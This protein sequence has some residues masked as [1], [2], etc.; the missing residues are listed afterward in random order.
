[1]KSPY[2]MVK[3]LQIPMNPS[4]WSHSCVNPHDM[5]ARWGHGA[6][7][8]TVKGEKISTIGPGQVVGLQPDADAVVAIDGGC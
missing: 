2:L 1:M 5:L 4:F 6:L 7:K 8:V 3:S